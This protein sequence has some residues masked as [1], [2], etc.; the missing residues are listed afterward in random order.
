MSLITWF[1]IFSQWGAPQACAPVKTSGFSPLSPFDVL[2]EESEFSTGQV[3]VFHRLLGSSALPRPP[4]PLVPR[5]HIYPAFESLQG[6]GPPGQPLPGLDNPFHAEISQISNLNLPWHNLRLF[7]LV[8]SFVP[9]KQS[10]VPLAVSKQSPGRPWKAVSCCRFQLQ[11]KDNEWGE[12]LRVQQDQILLS[13]SSGDAEFMKFFSGD[14]C[15][16][17]QPSRIASYK[18]CTGG[19]FCEHRNNKTSWITIVVLLLW[20]LHTM[21]KGHIERDLIELC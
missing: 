12:I 7:P 2:N 20:C 21:Q 9:W 16:I 17:N 13:V 15:D 10:P 1:I 18:A 5:C 3:L 4:L 14:K 8:L 19:N 11:H 6:W